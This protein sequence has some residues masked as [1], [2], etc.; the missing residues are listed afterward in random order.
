MEFVTDLSIP[1]GASVNDG[2]DP[3]LCSLTYVS[4]DQVTRTETG[5][6]PGQGQQQVG[7]LAHPRAP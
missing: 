5:R 7:L 3:R 4:V 1:E 6:P 2:I